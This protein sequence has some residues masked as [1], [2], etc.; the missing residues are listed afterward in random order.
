MKQIILFL[1]LTTI[2]FSQVDSM[3]V[4]W[5]E[6]T[7]ADLYGTILYGDTIALPTT[8]IDTVLAGTEFLE[9]KPSYAGL[10]RIRAKSLDDSS[11]T[12]AY[13]SIDTVTIWRD[14]IPSQFTFHDSVDAA[15]SSQIISGGVVLSGFDSAQVT[16]TGGDYRLS[17]LGTWTR[18]PSFASTG[19]TLWAVD[20]SS[21]SNSTATT[22]TV[23]IAGISDVFSVTTIAGAA[24]YITDSLKFYYDDDSLS[25]GAVS[26]WPPVTG[27]QNLS[28]ATAGY[29]PAMT[30][31]G[32]VFVNGDEYMLV[33]SAINFAQDSICTVEMVMQIPDSLGNDHILLQVN[34]T[35]LRMTV[36]FHQGEI[37]FNVYTTTKG[38]MTRK[39]ILG[40]VKGKMTHFAFT[41]DGTGFTNIKGYFNGVE[42]TP[43]AN[44]GISLD[45]TAGIG[46]GANFEQNPRAG[47]VIRLIRLYNDEFTSGDI[48]TNYNSTSV[49]G[50]DIE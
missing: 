45:A 21:A 18:S 39:F 5:T 19:D 48:T 8:V 41:S 26:S 36:G 3:R 12:S 31:T 15:V 37:Y 22:V 50:K 13:S 23:S 34:Q 27:G 28:Q 32:L 47:S 33:G 17:V 38:A 42:Q 9:W 4:T 25:N 24:A 14:S 6:A 20:T 30:D 10:W 29:Q 7:D 11:N 1:I 46:L 40:D 44:T 16:V 49:Q 35:P 2:S 43:T